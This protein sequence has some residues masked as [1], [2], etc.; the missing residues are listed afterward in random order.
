MAS[1]TFNVEIVASEIIKPSSPTPANLKTFKF[2]LLDQVSP[3]IY[4]PLVF[5]YPA[6]S[7]ANQHHDTTKIC[8]ILKESLSKT[9]TM[10]Y[11][12]AGRVKDHIS[13][14]CND[15][16]VTFTETR[17]NCL[18]SDVLRNP[19]LDEVGKLLPIESLAAAKTGNLLLI[20]VNF[21]ECSGMAIGAC[22]VHKIAD[23]TTFSIFIKTWAS[24]A[25]ESDEV[26]HPELFAGATLFPPVDYELPSNANALIQDESC[27]CKRFFFTA[28]N[29]DALKAKIAS[30]SV[31]QPTRV[32]AV[33]ALI[34][35]SAITASRS[36]GGTFSI[37]SLCV[38]G[39]NL[40]KRLSTPLLE[41]SVGNILS[42]ITAKFSETEIEL[43]SLI[44]KLRKELK[45]LKVSP[46]KIFCDFNEMME[47]RSS[48]GE[49]STHIVDAYIFSSWCRMPIYKTDF[50]WGKPTWVSL[51]NTKISNSI[52]L[53][54]AREGGGI[55]AWVTLCEE[56]MAIFENNE[57]LL[58]F[59]SV[60]P[61]VFEMT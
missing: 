48:R 13:I 52:V 42:V 2:S 46:E 56:K 5:F 3:L 10:Y 8:R 9:L 7:D 23:A 27:V 55:E 51:F 18:L 37:P 45:E 60:N 30:S 34:W 24:I 53:M 14:E 28:S 59:A 35:K 1:A 15:E 33:T 38:H 20:Q 17:I 16:G 6:K 57:E 31:Q 54:D 19:N 49:S 40:R 11:P 29:I 39:V 4:I 21:F 36:M 44:L 47:A 50:G 22:L 26:A 43:Q 32:E 61:N 58:S 12:F 41:Y 25:L